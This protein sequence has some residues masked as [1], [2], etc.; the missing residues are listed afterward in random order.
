M[1]YGAA[2]TLSGVVELTPRPSKADRARFQLVFG[3]LASVFLVR[4]EGFSA[5]LAGEGAVRHLDA[6]CRQWRSSAEPAAAGVGEKI[7]GFWS[8][9]SQESEY[10]A[11]PIVTHGGAV[12]DLYGCQLQWL[13]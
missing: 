4:P 1:L 7:L 8:L 5:W 10:A 12:L 3:L 13:E 2:G 9:P 11:G 6:C